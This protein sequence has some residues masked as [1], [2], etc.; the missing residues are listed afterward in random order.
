M[1]NS[2]PASL[3]LPQA[4]IPR[5][6][7]TDY[8]KWANRLF[9]LIRAHFVLICL[10]LIFAFPMFYMFS[11]SLKT[12]RQTFI[13]PPQ[14]WPNPFAWE[15]YPRAFQFIPY[16]RYFAN[17]FYVSS[18]NV[19]FTLASSSLVAYG[20]SKIKWFGRD[21]MFGLVVATLMIP[22]TVTLIPQF[23][24]FRQ[25]GWIGTYNPLI[26]PALGGHPFFIFLLRQFFRS[27]PLELSEA[28]RMDGATELGIFVRIILPLSKP[29]LVTVALFTFLWNW[30]D[31]LGPLIYV[32]KP[33]NY[34][35]A[36][37]LY[38]YFSL[39]STTEWGLLMAAAV[40]MILPVLILFLIGQRT[41]IR[42]I[43]T[44]GLKG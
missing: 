26:L 2:N 13:V 35:L 23:L 29:A 40:L 4:N 16:A 30:N 43:A 37:G 32:N 14:L 33:E 22:Y 39:R 12:L 9:R 8:T 31:F 41:F 3:S 18:L 25:L 38:N 6:Q 19:V 11:T 36:I 20:F 34:T 5:R 10:A 44:S 24:I 42:G 7:R 1:A 28:A 15:N 21:T 27:I 17:T